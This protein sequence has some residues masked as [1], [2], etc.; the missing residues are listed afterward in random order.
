[1]E[2]RLE[3]TLHLKL[4]SFRGPQNF[5]CR[6]TFCLRAMGLHTPVLQHFRN[7]STA[8]KAAVEVEI[9]ASSKPNKNKRNT[10]TWAQ[11]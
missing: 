11:R 8:L 4:G 1:M 7:S 5:S 9:N 6:V 2:N 10:A 3:A